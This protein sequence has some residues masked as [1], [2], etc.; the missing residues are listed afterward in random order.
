MPTGAKSLEVNIFGRSYKIA[1]EDGEREALLQAVAYLD[2]K[3]NDVRKTGK[4]T[5]TERIAVMVALNLAHELLATK[6]G[7]G[8]DLGQAKRRIAAIESKLDAALASQEKL[9]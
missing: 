6:L 5:G 2:G 9:F 4:V 7:S 3:M 8:F 1:C